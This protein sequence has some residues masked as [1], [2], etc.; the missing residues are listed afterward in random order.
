MMRKPND[1]YKLGRA[2]LIFL[3]AGSMGQ[4]QNSQSANPNRTVG[5]QPDGSVVVSDNQTLTPAGRI[6]E[7]GS[8]VRA[9]ALA[10]NPNVRT[11]SGAV[12]LMGSPQPIIVFN[13]TTGQIL[14]RFTPSF[15]RGTESTSSKAGSFT[16][17]T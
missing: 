11:N 3:I 15:M 12:L 2:V 9:K 1:V 5:P 10:L 17:I 4:A 13:T 6:I 14:Q 16:G 7:L 8:P